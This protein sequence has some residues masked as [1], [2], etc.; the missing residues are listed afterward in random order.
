VIVAAIQ[1]VRF[2]LSIYVAT[3]I[4]ARR[5]LF[6]CAL[7]STGTVRALAHVSASDLQFVSSE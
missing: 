1:V 4:D 7:D 2:H 5:N 6:V 3:H